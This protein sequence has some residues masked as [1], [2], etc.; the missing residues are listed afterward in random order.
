MALMTAVF[1][2]PLY[3]GSREAFVSKFQI[4]QKILITGPISTKHRD[5]EAT[6]IDVKP[7]THTR[8]GVTSLDKYIVQFPDGE[9]ATFFDIQLMA[10]PEEEHQDLQ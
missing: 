6:V 1:M 9:Q 5:R 4:G 8:P 2:R 3:I 7:N 10:A